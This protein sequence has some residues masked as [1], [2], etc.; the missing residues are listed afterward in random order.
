M[1]ARARSFPAPVGGWDTESA[2]SDMASDRAVIMDNWFPST[3]EVVLRPGHAEHATCANGEPVE[4]IIPYRA[5]SG[6]PK[7]FSAADSV[8]YDTSSSGA[9]TSAVT[10]QTSAVYQHTQMT[11]NAGHYLLIVNGA[12]AAKVYDG[13]TWA[14]AGITGVTLA[15]IAWISNHQNRIWFGLKGSAT[16]YYL[17]VEAIAGAATQFK[18]QSYLRFGGYLLNMFTWSRDGGNGPDDAAVFISSEGE[19][20]VFVG[21]DPSSSSAWALVGQYYIGRPIGRNCAIKAGADLLITTEAGV[22]PLSL[23]FSNDRSQDARI[24]LTSQVKKAL[25]DAVSEVGVTDTR[26]QTAIYPGGQMLIVNEPRSSGLTPR[27]IVFNTI[28]GAPC[29]FTGLD[30]QCWAYVNGNMYFGTSAGTVEQFDAA[31]D[32]DGSPIVADCVQAFHEFGAPGRVKSVH[33][34]EPIFRSYARPQYG[35]DIMR[36]WTVTDP[37]ALKAPGLIESAGVWDASSWDAATWQADDLPVWKGWR[38][39]RG[40]GKALALRLR[41]NSRFAQPR[42][43]QTNWLYHVGGAI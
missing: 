30:A 35:I 22:V 20:L 40:K 19:V 7:I 16:A 36:D 9:G 18:V 37:Q 14:S 6:A 33:R 15:D 1:A 24:A 34:V 2:V 10:G 5:P 12:D 43:S 23:A 25:S 41:I 29:R 11:N 42:W 39:V 38:S 26:W 13:S 27:Q 31:P 8:I 4:T 28:T 21:T 17:A 32:D 3:D